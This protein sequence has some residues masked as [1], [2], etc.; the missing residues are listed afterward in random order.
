MR[1]LNILRKTLNNNINS[2]KLSR[3]QN[4]LTKEIL[5][6]MIP[7]KI[8]INEEF[9]RIYTK[10]VGDLVKFKTGLYED[11]KDTIYRILEINKDRG[12]IELVNT[13]LPFPPQSIVILKELIIVAKGVK[14]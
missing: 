7:K 11:E 10:Q 13:K 12:I 8:A 2:K 4:K 1:N 6:T 9:Y 3:N 14:K 5:E